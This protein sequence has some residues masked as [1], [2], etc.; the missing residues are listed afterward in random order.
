MPN[1]TKN[2]KT[3]II[4]F[5]L[6]LVPYVWTVASLFIYFPNNRQLSIA[7]W[8]YGHFATYAFGILSLILVVIS[9]LAKN[10]S[11]RFA[12]IALALLGVALFV[13]R[14]G[15]LQYIGEKYETIR[16]SNISKEIQNIKLQAES[17]ETLTITF[18]D[19]KKAYGN[20]KNICYLH[21]YG[22]N[23]LT[24]LPLQLYEFKKLTQLNIS[25][26][27]HIPENEI[28]QIIKA[29]PNLKVTHDNPK[30]GFDNL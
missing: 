29:M 26:K 17:C 14:Q 21:I 30:A 5:I 9:L 6:S 2:S 7:I 22:S 20:R 23:N 3:A 15:G 27:N 25:P 16:Y 10:T 11:K 19:L 13:D 4:A 24:S 1:Q 12:Y 28:E 18:P 8:L